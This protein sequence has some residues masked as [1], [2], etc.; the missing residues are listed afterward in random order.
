MAWLLP[1]PYS[2]LRERD[3]LGVLWEP[4]VYP[5]LAHPNTE[6]SFVV[7][8]DASTTGMGAVLSQWQKDPPK[9]HPC[10]I[11]SKKLSMAEQNYAID[12]QEFLA[13]NLRLE[14]W[15]H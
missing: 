1:L 4:K 14:K 6:F 8:V 3:V 10:A 15:R 9:L 11:F 12:N 2:R 13:I 5:I 7:E